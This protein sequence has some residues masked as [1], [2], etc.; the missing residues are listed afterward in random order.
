MQPSSA[1]SSSGQMLTERQ[2][3]DTEKDRLASQIHTGV[4]N[5][6]CLFAKKVPNQSVELDLGT[7]LFE[8]EN[9]LTGGLEYFVIDE[10]KLLSKVA[11]N[12]DETIKKLSANKTAFAS[13]NFF[14]NRLVTDY[15]GKFESIGEVIKETEQIDDLKNS[16][17][18]KTV[19]L[20]VVQFKISKVEANK[21]MLQADKSQW[22]V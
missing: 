21:F 14:L 3:F 2:R 10:N 9:L 5:W 4:D 22:W 15:T 6:F 7:I 12:V 17:V 11:P 13:Y 18:F 20:A 19:C 16:K 8:K 1:L